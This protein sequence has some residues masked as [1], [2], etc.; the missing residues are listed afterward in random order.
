[1]KKSKLPKI[2]Q[3]QDQTGA[4]LW[5]GDEDNNNAIADTSSTKDGDTWYWVLHGRKTRMGF[6]RWDGTELKYC[7]EVP[8]RYVP[9]PRWWHSQV[10]ANPGEKAICVGGK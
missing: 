10:K 6:I 7:K 5:F 9:T 8:R 4:V 3:L 2:K 1:M